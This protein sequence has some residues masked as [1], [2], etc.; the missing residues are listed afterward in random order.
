M[1]FLNM[2]YFFFIT[3]SKFCLIPIEFLNMMIALFIIS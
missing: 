2:W 3:E 1:W